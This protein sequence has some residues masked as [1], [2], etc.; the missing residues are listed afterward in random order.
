MFEYSMEILTPQK[1]LTAHFL[2]QLSIATFIG[3]FLSAGAGGIQ[4]IL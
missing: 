4:Q 2:V 3:F 1:K